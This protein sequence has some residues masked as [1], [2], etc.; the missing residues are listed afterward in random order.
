MSKKNIDQSKLWGI[1]S[2]VLYALTAVNNWSIRH[3]YVAAGALICISAFADP[4]I[5]LSSLQVTGN[6]ALYMCFLPVRL[7]IWFFGFK[8]RGVEKGSYASQYQSRRYGGNI[9]RNSTF[10]KLQ[11]HGATLP[12]AASMLVTLLLYTGAVVVLVREW[13]SWY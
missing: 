5:L 13:W 6:T 10:A 2:C 9:P 1:L 8:G 3:P 12:T 11:A 4:E 7:S